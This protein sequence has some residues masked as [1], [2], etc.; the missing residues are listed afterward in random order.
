MLLR[1]RRLTASAQR[2]R[3]TN[4]KGV[5]RVTD[6]TPID[7]LLD[8]YWALRDHPDCAAAIIITRATVQEVVEE[9]VELGEVQESVNADALMHTL[10][11]DGFT[12]DFWFAWDVAVRELLVSCAS[13]TFEAN[14]GG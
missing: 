9:L 4:R 5:E 10:R 3:T 2:S 14:G 13:R 11:S 7:S 12:G 1:L 6:E 8:R